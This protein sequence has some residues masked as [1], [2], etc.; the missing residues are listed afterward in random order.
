MSEREH[1][2]KVE[3]KPADGVE[4][5]RFQEIEQ[6]LERIT[7]EIEDLLRRVQKRRA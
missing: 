2:G 7:R 4:K 1:R 5:E 3:K 6:N